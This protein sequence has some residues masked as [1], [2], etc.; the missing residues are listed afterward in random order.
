MISFKISPFDRYDNLFLRH[1]TSVSANPFL[2][3]AQIW[4]AGPNDYLFLF[5]LILI[6]DYDSECPYGSCLYH[7][8]TIFDKKLLF[9]GKSIKQGK[10]RIK[11]KNMAEGKG[12][13]GIFFSIQAGIEIPSF[14]RWSPRIFLEFHSGIRIIPFGNSYYSPRNENRIMPPNI[15]SKGIIKF[16][17]L[18]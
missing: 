13:E 11:K 5:P 2:P 9:D 12:L 3:R 17:L 14:S 4:V 8:M 6:Q 18:R 10:G 1:N 16:P 7:L 15:H